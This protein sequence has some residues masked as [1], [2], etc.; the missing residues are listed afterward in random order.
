MA[1]QGPGTLIPLQEVTPF[2]YKVAY[3]FGP[4]TEVA[5][6]QSW[7]DADL[8]EATRLA[9]GIE[10]RDDI[11]LLVFTFQHSA[12]E[13]MEIPRGRVE[14]GPEVS[15][16]GFISKD[17]VFLV[18]KGGILGLAPGIPCENPRD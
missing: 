2:G 12:M 8:E 18:K 1:E 14:F 6:M 3:I 16:C 17:A 13:S 7:L 4:Y 11:H 5:L 9:R 10:R 15:K